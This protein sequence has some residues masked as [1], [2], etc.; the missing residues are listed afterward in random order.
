MEISKEILN[1]IAD[2]VE[3]GFKCFIHKETHEVVTYLDPDSYPDMDVAAWKEE[4]G[5]VKKDRKKFIEIESMNSSERFKVMEEFVYSL[6]DNSTKL[7]LLRALEG[8]KPFANFKHQIENSDHE[9]QLWFAFR[10]EKN[11]QWVEH[12]LDLDIH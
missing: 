12:Q 9:R 11:M 10:R 6:E 4:I 8:H 3:A 1:D 5:K 2:S 7:R